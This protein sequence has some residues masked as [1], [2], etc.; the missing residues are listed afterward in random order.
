MFLRLTTPRQRPRHRDLIHKCTDQQN[1]WLDMT[2][3]DLIDLA[4]RPSTR[5]G[6]ATLW[7]PRAA[8]T[9]GDTG[10]TAETLGH[11]GLA[12]VAGQIKITDQRR[13]EA[14]QRLQRQG[15]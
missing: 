14:Y 6:C 10:L 1:R 5:I 3:R 15:L 4:S 9:M 13:R 7:A 12:S 2:R 11:R 8:E